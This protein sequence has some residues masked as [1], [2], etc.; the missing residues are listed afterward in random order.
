MSNEMSLVKELRANWICAI[1][2]ATIFT[3]LGY[4]FYSMHQ[5]SKDCE[6]IRAS[7]REKYY[8]GD[9]VQLTVGAKASIS[10]KTCN[11]KTRRPY[12]FVWVYDVNAVGADGTIHRTTVTEVE[13]E[14]LIKASPTRRVMTPEDNGWIKVESDYEGVRVFKGHH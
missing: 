10:D 8:R 4:C 5:D 11:L 3:V 12:S 2:F 1:I 6:R 13:I 14:S 7:T 9:I